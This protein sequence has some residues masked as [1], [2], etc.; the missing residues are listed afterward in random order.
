[1]FDVGA[2]NNIIA[3]CLVYMSAIDSALTSDAAFLVSDQVTLADICFACEY[4]MFSREAKRGEILSG[5][6]VQPITFETAARFPRAIGYFEQLCQHKAFSPDLR[7][8]KH[9][10]FDLVDCAVLIRFVVWHCF[11]HSPLR[12]WQNFRMIG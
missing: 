2:S 8:F 11:E 10:F 9:I 5:I 7:G 3:W 12:F 1:M 6:G 4:V